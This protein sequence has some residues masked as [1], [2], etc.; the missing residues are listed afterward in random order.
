MS[1]KEF[2]SRMRELFVAHFG[3]DFKEHRLEIKKRLRE[4]EAPEI[5]ELY[6]FAVYTLHLFG[7]GVRYAN[8]RANQYD[9]WEYDRLNKL[10]KHL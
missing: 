4:G 10:F 8:P 9:V 6:Q 1:K 3:A 5:N 7:G 2:Y